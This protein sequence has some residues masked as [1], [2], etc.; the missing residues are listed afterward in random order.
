[1]PEPPGEAASFALTSP[2]YDDGAAIPR[3][4]TCD[5]DDV[6]PALAWRGA[7]TG[8]AS[9]A[10]TLLDPDA[11]RGPFVHWVRFDIPA[12]RTGLDEGDRAHGRDGRNDFGRAGYGGPC[13][14]RGHGAHRYVATLHALDVPSLGLGDGATADE[15]AAAMR[16]RVLATARLVGRYG[17]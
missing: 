17:R 16:G 12:G 14:P 8:T 10:L 3:H 13:P 5:G 15:V 4:H 9:L 7:P 1:M 6:S 2:A 11:P